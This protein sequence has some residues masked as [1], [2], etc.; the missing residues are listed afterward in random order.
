MKLL[1]SLAAAL[2][3]TLAAQ[4]AVQAQPAPL[5][6]LADAEGDDSG[7]GSLVYPREP[8]AG[9]GDLDLRTL[10]VVAEGELL[11]FEATFKNPVRDPAQVKSGLLGSE[12]LSLFA[13]RGF[14]AFNLDIYLDLDRVPGSGHSVALPGRRARIDP[15]HAWERAIVLTPRPELMRRQL[16]D[17]LAEA[18]GAPE[19]AALDALIDGAVFFVRDARVRGRTVSF[20]VPA[21]FVDARGLASASLIALVTAA[22]LSVE[23]DLLS[24]LARGGSSAAAGSALER[25]P[26]GVAAP[27]SGRPALAMG[28]RSDKPPAT[29]I[30]DLLAADEA[31]QRAQLTRGLLVGLGG[32]SAAMGAAAAAAAKADPWLQRA[33]AG[34]SAAA[35]GAAAPAPV[36]ATA[37]PPATTTITSPATPPAAVPPAPLPA[38]L[39]ASAAPAASAARAAAAASAPARVRDAAYLEEQENRLRTLK[40]L[41]DANLITE[42]EYQRKRKEIIDAL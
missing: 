1:R 40:R 34:G 28:Y 37:T 15:A 19:G 13:R 29:A 18:P 26:L 5:V 32:S 21:R 23:S 39:A 14:Y 7:D 33:L 12:D 42:E 36:A 16:R 3:F 6:N 10:R 4:L 22:K 24:G 8:I 35:A 31:S 20:T 9:P 2:F 41:R 38:T 25:L 17:A 30:V 11:R 27:E